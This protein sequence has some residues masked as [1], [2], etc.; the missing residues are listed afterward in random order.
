MSETGFDPA[1][2]TGS[3]P[4]DNVP[5]ELSVCVGHARPLVRELMA[6]QPGAVLPLTSR[7]DDPVELYVGDRLVGLG[8]LQL[9]ET[10]GEEHLSVHVTELMDLGTVT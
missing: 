4:F 3:S 7:L 9:V 8:L 10:D 2:A 5:I 1:A 6:L